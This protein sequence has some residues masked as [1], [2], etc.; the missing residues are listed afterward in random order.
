[1]KP[2]YLLD[3][4]TMPIFDQLQLE[5]AL[6]RGTSH[7]YCLVSRGSSK[8]IVMGISGKIELLL[9]VPKVQ[10]HAVPVI[11]R[12]S[13]GGTVIVDKETLFTTF[14]FSKDDIPI[15]PYPE[16]ILR[17]TAELFTT[18]WQIPNFHLIENDYAI[19]PMKC[20]G[21][22]QYIQKDRWLHHTSF[23]FDY[24]NENMEYLQ[25]PE[26]RPTYRKN[27][28]HTDFLCRLKDHA[29]SKEHLIDQL[30]IEL[31]K[32]FQVTPIS[33]DEL[34]WNPHRQSVRQVTEH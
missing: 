30:K 2:I 22:A 1:L 14:I 15:H 12:F 11:Q 27:R 16:P 13:G 32:R 19:G 17:W 26:K 10:E 24:Q 6:L 28:T 20:G 4:G 9:N 25:L 3:L 23:L 31:N 8:A 5:E 18:A 7:N 21:N 29:P 34:T 33:L